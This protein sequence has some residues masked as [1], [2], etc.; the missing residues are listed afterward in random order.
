MKTLFVIASLA[1]SLFLFWKFYSILILGKIENL[2]GR[3]REAQ[4]LNKQPFLKAY[5]LINLGASLCFLSF[6]LFALLSSTDALA[7][8]LSF[9]ILTSSYALLLL[10]I[11]RRF[12]RK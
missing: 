12:T 11:E 5:S 4:H 3:W 2:G 9:L 7:L 8:R 1:L 10:F 6:A